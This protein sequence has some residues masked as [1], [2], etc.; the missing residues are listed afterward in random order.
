[1]IPGKVLRRVLCVVGLS[2]ILAFAVACFFSGAIRRQAGLASGSGGPAG[3]L[4]GKQSGELPGK[5]SGGSA[6]G[7]AISFLWQPGARQAYDVR[8]HLDIDL[9]GSAMIDTAQPLHLELQGVLNFR[10]LKVDNEK[11][12]AA[13]QLRPCQAMLNRSSVDHE[14]LGLC[15]PFRVDFRKNGVIHSMAFPPGL[16]KEARRMLGGLLYA[17]QVALPQAACGQAGEWTQVERDRAGRYEA[18]YGFSGEGICK[19]K[20]RYLS[21]GESGRRKVT[22]SKSSFLAGLSASASW[23]D[24]LRGEEELRIGR[25]N[26]ASV[27]SRSTIALS[28]LSSV[29][30]GLALWG[31]SPDSLLALKEDDRGEPDSKQKPKAAASLRAAADGYLAQLLEKLLALED[32]DRPEII[33]ALRDLFGRDSGSC[34]SIV[35]LLHAEKY[36]KI[37]PSILLALKLA[38]TGPAQSSLVSIMNGSAQDHALRLGAIAQLGSLTAP[39]SETI[40][41]LWERFEKR[42]DSADDPETDLSNT[43]VLALGA[44]ANHSRENNP[45]ITN[46]I[47]ERLVLETEENGDSERL[48]FLINAMGN[49]GAPQVVKTVTGFLDSADNLIRA[50]AAFACRNLQDEESA[51][52]LANI[53]ETDY[54]PKVRTNAAKALLERSPGDAEKRVAQKRLVDE[55]NQETRLLL[56]RIIAR[57]PSFS[58]EDARLLQKFATIE[59]SR[60]VIKEIYKHITPDGKPLP[61]KSD[62]SH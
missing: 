38:G 41:S 11:V 44:L 3:G 20:L 26:A 19:R 21:S 42:T 50:K 56:I 33:F 60:E 9:S 13:I 39:G 4:A 18:R 24:S 36:R 27:S 37:A 5:P 31:A 54:S 49:T 53:L 59:T 34:R 6:Q 7:G 35:E 12:S 40:N 52:K 10:L 17:A 14:A 43:A 1:M 2:I 23:L 45:F 25:G 47:S 32:K 55:Q 30:E 48:V 22:I 61:G 46:E 28:R 15:Q 8:R 51:A 62:K 57:A 58:Q 29:E 16:S